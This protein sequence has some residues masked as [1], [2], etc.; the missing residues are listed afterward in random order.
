MKTRPAELLEPKREAA[1]LKFGFP[2]EVAVLT[3]VHDGEDPDVTQVRTTPPHAEKETCGALKLCEL[4][5]PDLS[6]SGFWLW[7]GGFVL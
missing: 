6:L 5:L 4:H 1:G 2:A 7:F 3:E